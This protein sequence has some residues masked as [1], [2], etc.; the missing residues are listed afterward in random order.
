MPERWTPDSWR[1]KPIVQVPDYPDAAKLAAVE[2]Q[3]ASF[4]PQQRPAVVRT[5]GVASR[6]V[7]GDGQAPTFTA[8]LEAPQ[9]RGSRAAA[10]AHRSIA[11]A[12]L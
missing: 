2:A 5:P 4:P 1:G 6:L 12:A 10:T 8:R 11:A 7:R 9:W 3:L